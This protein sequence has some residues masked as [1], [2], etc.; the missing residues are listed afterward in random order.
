MG[1]RR[2]ATYRYDAQPAAANDAPSNVCDLSVFLGLS[3]EQ[4]FVLRSRME[5]ATEGTAT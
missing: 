1:S 3:H 2:L 5:M 4:W